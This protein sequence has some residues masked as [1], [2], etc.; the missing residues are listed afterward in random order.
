L[1]FSDRQAVRISNIDDTDAHNFYFATNF[2]KNGKFSAPH[3]ILK[4]N[5]TVMPLHTFQNFYSK[6]HNNSRHICHL[7]VV[8]GLIAPKTRKISTVQRRKTNNVQ[9][10]CI[11]A[12]TAY[13]QYQYLCTSWSLAL[14]PISASQPPIASTSFIYNFTAIHGFRLRSH[15]HKYEYESKFW[16][17]TCRSFTHTSQY[18]VSAILK[19]YSEIESR[20]C[21]AIKTT[22]FHYIVTIFTNHAPL[23]M[24]NFT[25]TSV[26]MSIRSHSFYKLY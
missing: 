23:T 9:T 5:F 22:I 6:C 19:I 10:S 18:G 2:I 21:F 24:N 14:W 25:M 12:Y 3:F 20:K 26:L 4:E 17:T 11:W 15:R 13:K 16:L 8:V 7:D 1:Q